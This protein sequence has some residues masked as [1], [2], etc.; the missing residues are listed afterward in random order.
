VEVSREEFETWGPYLRA[1]SGI[2]WDDSQALNQ[3]RLPGVPVISGELFR[4]LMEVSPSRD[5]ETSVR[6]GQRG[7]LS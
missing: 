2:S 1:K 7:R 5:G 4:Q 3:L 6:N